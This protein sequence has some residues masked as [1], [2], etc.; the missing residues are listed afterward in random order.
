ML[1]GLKDFYYSLEEKWYGFLDKIETKIHIYGLIDKIDQVIPSFILFLLIILLIILFGAIFLLGVTGIPPG[2]DVAF[3][4]EV[5]NSDGELQSNA[6]VTLSYADQVITLATNSLG[7]TEPVT[8]AS[9]TL[10]DISVEKEGYKPTEIKQFAVT[11]NEAKQIVLE[12]LS[13][14]EGKQWTFKLVGADGSLLYGERFD[15]S[16]A[17]N[18]SDAAPPSDKT[19]SSPSVTVI[20][21]QDCDGLSVSINSTKFKP[22]YSATISSNNQEIRLEEKTTADNTRLQVIVSDADSQQLLDGIRIEIAA[23]AAASAVDFGDTVNGEK[24]FYDLLPQAYVVRVF[25]RAANYRP[26]SKNVVLALNDTTIVEFFLQKKTADANVPDTNIPVGIDD[27]LAVQIV[28]AGN[29]RQIDN[30][31]VTLKKGTDVVAT[32]RSDADKNSLI[33]FVVPDVNASYTITVDHEDYFLKVVPN[34]KPAT[35]AYIIELQPFIASEGGTLKI[36]VFD[37]DKKP[38]KGATV[39]LADKEQFILGYE[40]QITD[41]N[42]T[43]I[44]NRITNGSYKA[45]AFKG[46][47][48]GW[49]DEFNFQIKRIPTPVYNLTLRTENGIIRIIVA[50]K[51]NVPLKFAQ[52]TFFDSLGDSVIGT[53]TIEDANGV[54]DFVSRADKTIYVKAAKAGYTTTT[55]Q[56]IEVKPGLVQELPIVLER[57][58]ISGDVKIRFLGLYFNGEKAQSLTADTQYTARFEMVIPKEAE[59]SE[60]GI[61]IRV[62]N[63]ELVE[64]D[65]AFIKEIN[66]P[67]AAITKYSRYSE[68]YNNDKLSLTNFE[69]KWSNIAWTNPLSGVFEVEAIIKTKDSAVL[70]DNIPIHYRAWAKNSKNQTL[71]DPKD[72]AVVL[73]KEWYANSFTENFAIGAGTICSSEFCFDAQILDKEANII[74]GVSDNY[75]ARL[76]KDYELT[77]TLINNAVSFVHQN[78]ELRIKNVNK[79]LVFTDYNIITAQ[80]NTL[81]NTVALNAA[82]LGR[83]IVGNLAPGNRVKGTIKFST[84]KTADNI[85]EFL[86]VSDQRIRFE[87]NISV[88]VE[89]TKELK[90]EVEP[91]VIPALT[92]NTL[93]ITIK[94]KETSLEV[95]NVLVKIKDRFG[96]VLASGNTNELGFASLEIAS[97]DP[98]TQLSMI[99]EIEGYKPLQRTLAISEKFIEVS[100]ES[101]GFLLN[102][103]TKKEDLETIEVNNPLYFDVMI[104]SFSIEGDLKNLIDKEKM[105]NFLT[106]QNNSLIKSGKKREFEVKAFLAKDAQNISSPKNVSGK[107]VLNAGNTSGGSWTIDVP[108]RFTI[109]LGGEVDLSSCFNISKSSW[110]DS[111]EGE[112]VKL[113][114]ELQNNC[115][116]KGSPIDLKNV[117]AM[118]E[119]QG[120]QVGEFTLSIP[121]EAATQLRNSYFRR[122]IGILPKDSSKTAELEFSPNGGVNGE[123]KA[124]III[125]AVNVTEKGEQVLEDSIDVSIRTLNLLECV[126]FSNNLIEFDKSTQGKFNVETLD[127]GESVKFVFDSDLEIIPKTITLSSKQKSPDIIISPQNKDPGQYLINAKIETQSTKVKQKVKNLIVRIN[128]LATDCLHLNKYEYDIYDDPNS[129][130]DGIDSGELTNSCIDKTVK[131]KIDVKSWGNAMKSALPWSLVALAATTIV[132][133]KGFIAPF[134]KIGDLLNK[135]N[136]TSENDTKPPENDLGVKQKPFPV[137]P[138]ATTANPAPATEPTAPATSAQP[139]ETST[140]PATATTT[141]P[142]ATST[143]PALLGY[144]EK[145]TVN[146]QCESNLCF[147]GNWRRLP[148]HGKVCTGINL[149]NGSDCYVDQECASGNCPAKLVYFNSE[150]YSKCEENKKNLS[151]IPNQEQISLQNSQSPIVSA[152]GFVDLSGIANVD[153]RAAASPTN[154]NLGSIFQGGIIGAA[155][156]LVK[157]IVGGV[158]PWVAG[159]GTF[160]I[161]TVVNYFNQDDISLTVVQPDLIMKNIGLFLEQTPLQEIKDTRIELAAKE[162]ETE[163]VGGQKIEKTPLV[164]KNAVNLIQ[165][166]ALTPFFST[167]KNEGDRQNYKDKKYKDKLPTNASGDFVLET[168][169]PTK[170]EQKFHLQF[171]A[172]NPS[173]RVDVG[174]ETPSCQI[175]AKTG[176]TGAIALPLVDFD[177]SWNNSSG[178]RCDMDGGKTF[179]DAAQLS[180]ELTE[181][182]KQIDE[183]FAQNASQLKCPAGVTCPAVST[184]NL[185]AYY[186]FPNANIPETEKQKINSLL[187]FDALLIQDG[188]SNDFIKDFDDY[189]RNK[190]FANTPEYYINNAAGIGLYFKDASRLKFDYTK[191]SSNAPISGPGKYGIEILIDYASDPAW[192]L[193]KGNTTSSG[194]GEKRNAAITIKFSKLSSP[195]EAVGNSSAFYYLPF[196]GLLGKDNSRIGYGADFSGTEIKVNDSAT[197]QSVATTTIPNSVPVINAK[198]TSFNDF[199]SLNT[200]SALKGNTL[201]IDKT[202]DEINLTYSPSYATPLQLEIDHS[203]AR[204]DA[205]AFYSVE[206]NGAAQNTGESLA[207]WHGV[208]S[209]CKD[210]NDRVLSS[211][212]DATN[213]L[214]GLNNNLECARLGGDQ[215]TAYGLEWC[216]PVNSGKVLLETVLYTPVN[217]DAIIKKF[218][219]SD[220]AGMKFKTINNGGVQSAS[221]FSL[222]KGESVSSIEKIFNLVKQ[223]KM[224]VTTNDNSTL[225]W[226]NPAPLLDGPNGELLAEKENFI[227]NQC[228]QVK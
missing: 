200:V 32:A 206:I 56:A 151:S 70:G 132:N 89:E 96:S 68:N 66:A 81:R 174:P 78:A 225:F 1:E 203:A 204:E 170:L 140:A 92:P 219:S 84:K 45:F 61:N 220:D 91:I 201:K 194:S 106:E 127:C 157:V 107:L 49:T 169:T 31:L 141:K 14:T 41:F 48:K 50:D 26:A 17:C 133:P 142:P 191:T 36:Q 39:E 207:K 75:E 121:L 192:K 212:F 130:Y 22:I 217:S 93:S 138:P 158:N 153:V 73:G 214:H 118:I 7:E 123:A 16:F 197:A 150:G 52:L 13:T 29:K 117:E 40:P 87:K 3:K 199:K 42:G 178:T 126:S 145:C 224:C 136:K 102:P 112:P 11:T 46:Y 98:L 146:S 21:P 30:A 72:S 74:K 57:E 8:I 186:V 193:F 161:G 154:L 228:I 205:F 79:G 110:S 35:G 19:I 160:V 85:V 88:K 189:A 27:T 180:I 148:W 33:E 226:W 149:S 15:L 156:S 119:W 62:G 64:N 198:Q 125:H 12:K 171:N 222:N 20:E 109:G 54:Y 18:N 65:I 211:A 143:V 44:F 182:L 97:Q 2:G 23:S 105:N 55:T 187:N 184:A 177:W 168:G 172:I 76:F 223:K 196:D 190:S 135:D 152:T 6:N 167:L 162:K 183:W 95:G 103:Q 28:E 4:I 83:I 80:G 38:V 131:T 10:I 114:I 100:P 164:F 120:N 176:A 82:D 221:Q 129:L 51:E 122:F 111:T 218:A 227:K 124:K 128:P 216:S 113:D 134:K 173:E 115:T 69:S 90:S 159:I 202:G 94:D 99:A 215:L 60:A 53:K 5:K 9:G 71:R 59:Y 155:Q 139:P 188:Y 24:T 165:T 37:L 185:G 108:L 116:V 25:D 58:T 144:K 213:D 175:G 47:G 104:N 163:I 34:L 166:D 43:A 137:T 195:Q 209:N 86:L 67:N 63:T 208:G 179:C 210:F 101:I 147:G 181:R 77:F